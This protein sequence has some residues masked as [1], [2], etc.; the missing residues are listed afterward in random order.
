MAAYKGKEYS[1]RPYRLYNPLD[2]G[3][4]RWAYYADLKRAHHAA[5]RHCDRWAKI[6]TTIQ[7]YNKNTGKES[8]TYVRTVMGVKII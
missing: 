6:G 5:Q 2:G 1:K 8:G 4:I 7:V 3:E